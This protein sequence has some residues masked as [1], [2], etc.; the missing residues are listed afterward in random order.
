MRSTLNNSSPWRTEEGR[1]G[2]DGVVAEV[3]EVHGVE[4]RVLN[5]V[6]EVRDLE[7]EDAVRGQQ[8][9]DAVS[10]IRQLVGMGE[11]VVGGDDGRLDRSPFQAPGQ[12]R[13]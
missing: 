12:A 1:Q 2:T 11:D 13:T 7:A 5:D 4:E 10:H 6:H 3:F 9:A 8:F